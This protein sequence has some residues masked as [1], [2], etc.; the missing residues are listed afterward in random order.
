MSGCDAGSSVGDG[1]K[2][3]QGIPY[4]EEAG[5]A[6]SSR[7][8]RGDVIPS[9]ARDLL[10]NQPEEQIPRFARDGRWPYFS[11]AIAI[12]F[13]PTVSSNFTLTSSPVL[14]RPKSAVGGLMP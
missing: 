5:G 6:M 2:W 13:G 8:G 4:S 1:W 9:E 14:S 10:F 11:S 12:A 3:W 7:A